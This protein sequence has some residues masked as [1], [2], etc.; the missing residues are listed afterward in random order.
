MTVYG[1]FFKAANVVATSNQNRRHV[2]NAVECIV[3]EIQNE[4]F[5][6]IRIQIKVRV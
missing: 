4:M 3:H 1:F 6:C 2:M 5:C